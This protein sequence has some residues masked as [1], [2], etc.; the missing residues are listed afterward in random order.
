M[1]YEAR[2]EWSTQDPL[3][4]VISAARAERKKARS[5][6]YR[7]R[8]P[9]RSQSPVEAAELFIPSP[10]HFPVALSRMFGF[11]PPLAS[12][13]LL[14]QYVKPTEDETKERSKRRNGKVSRGSVMPREVCLFP[15]N[16]RFKKADWV[17]V[18]IQS[19]KRG[20]DCILA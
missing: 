17:N 6:S 9:S 1:R 14:K 7:R 3:P 12:D 16:L 11:L 18:P 19:D 10:G 4:S 15:Y 20:Y 2:I 5:S 13:K 8:S